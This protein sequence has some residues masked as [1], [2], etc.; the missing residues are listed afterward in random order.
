MQYPKS[1]NDI[2]CIGP[3]Y[4]PNTHILHPITLEYVTDKKNPFCP[5]N[6]WIKSDVKKIYID[7]CKNPTEDKDTFDQSLDILIPT[8]SFNSMYFLKVY[9]QITSFDKA[10]DWLNNNKDSSYNTKKRILDL[11]WKS[12][13]RGLILDDRTIDYHVKLAGDYWVND[14]YDRLKKYIVVGKNVKLGKNNKPNPKDMNVVINYIKV[15]LITSGI[16]QKFIIKYI[17]YYKNKWSSIYSHINN[18]KN[19]YIKYLISKINSTT[20]I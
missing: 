17:N 19:E 9:Y 6:E 4:K 16:F 1:N 13:G 7:N 12:F 8:V 2:Q 11:S 14:I 5:T 18:I 10:F 20:N 15:K 3:C